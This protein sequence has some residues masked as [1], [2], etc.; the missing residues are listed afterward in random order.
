MFKKLLHITPDFHPD[1]RKNSP[2]QK[3]DS[4]KRK[5]GER[6]GDNYRPRIIPNAAASQRKSII[7]QSDYDLANGTTNYNDLAN[8]AR[9]YVAIPQEQLLHRYEHDSQIP[10]IVDTNVTKLMPFGDGSNK[11]FG[12]ENFGHTCYCNSVLQCIYNLPEFRKSILQFPQR[13]PL[14]SRVRVE[15]FHSLHERN[16]INEVVGQQ[17]QEAISI[18]ESVTSLNSQQTQTRST[19]T[20]PELSSKSQSI[21]TIDDDK[22]KENRKSFFK[23]LYKIRTSSSNATDSGYLGDKSIYTEYSADSSP[24][25]DNTDKESYSNTTY[26]STNSQSKPSQPQSKPAGYFDTVGEKLHGDCRKVIVGN[27][28]LNKTYSQT[29]FN[30]SE[31]SNDLN[32]EIRKKLALIHGPVIN[33]DHLLYKDQP[34]FLYYALKDIMEC[35]TE[36][37]YLSGVV[38]PA[39]FVKLL[40]RQN[41]L[42]NSTMQQDAH[43]F[44]NFLLNN[45][46]DFAGKYKSN[47]LKSSNEEECE[48]SHDF[49][50]DQF[51]GVLL[52]RI[53]CLTCDCVS[54]NEEPFLDFPIEIQNDEAINIQDTFRSFYQREILCGPNKFYCN[55]CC[56][57]QEAEKTVGFEKLPKTL[58][59]HLKRFKCDGIVNSKLFNK[60]EYPLTLTVCSCFDNSLCKTYEL[61]GVVLHVGASPT[62]GHYVS[63][64]KHEKYGWLMYDDETIES[65]PEE[66][67][68]SHVG[69]PNNPIT[70]YVL[71]YS[72]KIQNKKT[73]LS[74]ELAY[75]N[76]INKLMSYETWL[77]NKDMVEKQ[78]TTNYSNITTNLSKHS[79]CAPKIAQH[80][81]RRP[82]FLTFIST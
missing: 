78:C 75:N 76:N 21:K 69:E 58:A 16:Y 72:E 11:V 12:Y 61:T 56:G 17:E 67:V 48:I 37:R 35:I 31:S 51:E 39:E 41:P 53:K 42:F 24:K 81:K 9:N 70:A 38:S 52:N 8:E 68:T 65:I 5:S 82:K 43:E 59:L 2:V 63:I 79:K 33:I 50:K 29:Y 55:E 34:H 74:D 10:T 66:A 14:K 64:C 36:N 49:V 46:S 30:V 27:P 4:F 71:F 18:N 13:Y 73:Q 28:E 26:D 44:L 1:S 3:E 80:S 20:Q 7:G 54:A 57:L 62:H 25:D 23:D 40:K 19:N 60:I 47:Y 45:I 32:I 22:K 6:I 77:R 15:E